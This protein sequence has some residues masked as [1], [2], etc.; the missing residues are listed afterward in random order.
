MTVN[1]KHIDEKGQR[2]NAKCKSVFLNHCI[3]AYV[4]FFCFLKTTVMLFY[5]E[6]DYNEISAIK[7]LSPFHIHPSLTRYFLALKKLSFKH[8]N[9]LLV[10]VT[11]SCFTT[12]YPQPS[13]HHDRVF[14]KNNNRKSPL[15]FIKSY[16]KC[17]R[18]ITLLKINS[19]ITRVGFKTSSF[20]NYF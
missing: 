3:F 12:S 8:N 2:N 5:K 11:N 18:K 6:I 4:S 13:E 17:V 9:V 1:L 7:K 15:Y 20:Q 14:H 10:L 19:F 16:F